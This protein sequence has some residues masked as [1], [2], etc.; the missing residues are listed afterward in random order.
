MKKVLFGAMAALTLVACSNDE[1]TDVTK[2]KEI[3]FNVTAGK[4]VTRAADGYCNAAKPADFD[5]WARQANINYFA[6]TNFK[7]SDGQ[8]VINDATLRYWPETGT[9]D[10]FAMKNYNGTVTWDATSPTAPLTVADYTVED[11]VE[12]QKDFIYAV[13]AGVMNKTV[14]ELNFRHA[15]SQIEFQAKNDNKNIYVEITG[16]KVVNVANKGTLTLPTATTDNNF[17]DHLNGVNG[18]Y[19]ANVK[20]T[21]VT[22]PIATSKA[23]YTMVATNGNAATTAEVLGNNTAVGITTANATS[24]EYSNQTLYVMPQTVEAWNGTGKPS[25]AAEAYFALTCKIWNVAAGDGSQDKS[26]L[27]WDGTSKDIAVCIPAGTVWEQGK[28]YVYTFNFTKGGNGG[29]DPEGNPVFTAIKLSVTVDDFAAG[30]DKDVD[31]IK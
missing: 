19:N 6:A 21:W 14:A 24:K 18:S 9:L 13:S 5:V 20:G 31:M 11:A 10:F 29:I 16:V 22:T 12:N 7:L 2:S 4:A 8:W 1:V 3:K 25:Q 26:V 30:T 17:E 23:T 15:L 27:V 28:R